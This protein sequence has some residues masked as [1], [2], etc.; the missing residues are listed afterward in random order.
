VKALKIPGA[1]DDHDRRSHTHLHHGAFISRLSALP[2]QTASVTPVSNVND[3]LIG[4]KLR[5]IGRMLSY[6][7]IAALVLI[8]D[9]DTALLVDVSLCVDPRTS[10]KWIRERKSMVFVLGYL[11]RSNTQLII[12]NLPSYSL[13]PNINPS[14]VIRALLVYPTLP[15]VDLKL[16]NEILN[17]HDEV[18]QPDYDSYD[19]PT[20]VA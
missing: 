18:G 19:W 5:L 7:S 16:W 4:R 15:D 20:G 8:Q 13:A 9:Q 14:L 1:D 17:E 2:Q 12:P 10:G 11:E 6:D 3:H